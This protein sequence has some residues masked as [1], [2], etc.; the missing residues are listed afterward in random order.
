MWANDNL[1]F[2]VLTKLMVAPSEIERV[3]GESGLTFVRLPS[4]ARLSSGSAFCAF[5]A[6][7]EQDWRLLLFGETE[8]ADGVKALLFGSEF[9]GNTESAINVREASDLLNMIFLLRG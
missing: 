4:V 9:K 1:P 2:A 7:D 5:A 6:H 3:T 8:F